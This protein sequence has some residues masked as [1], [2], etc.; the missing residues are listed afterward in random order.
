MK[1]SVSIIIPAYN[2]DKVLEK[3]LKNIYKIVNEVFD[4]YELLIV[5]DGSTDR[6]GEIID[7]FAKKHSGIRPFHNKK[8]MNLGYNYRLGIKNAT[9]NYVMLLPGPDNMT[10][11]SIKKFM[12]NVGTDTVVIG[13]IANQD[14]RPLFRRIMSVFFVNTLNLLFGLR[15]KHY[16]TLQSYETKSVQKV[17]LTTNSFALPAEILIRLLKRGY[18]YKEVPIYNKELDHNKTMC[19]RFRNLVGIIALVTRLLFEINFGKRAK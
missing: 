12:S 8:N 3:T 10:L 1:K 6:T 5:D 7:N 16:M 17:K 11:D 13:Y 9:K 14:I 19:F 2:E 15:L 18:S 4:N